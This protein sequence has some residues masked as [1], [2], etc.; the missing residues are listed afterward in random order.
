MHIQLY[1]DCKKFTQF[2]RQ[3]WA[4]SERIEKY[5]LQIVTK[6]DIKIFNDKSKFIKYKKINT[7]VV[8]F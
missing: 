1:A 6:R 8:N 3:R 5:F 7:Y 2:Q 4:G